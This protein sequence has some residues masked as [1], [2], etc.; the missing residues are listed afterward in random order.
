MTYFA[1]LKGINVTGNKTIKM[2]ELKA[3]FESLG[4][5]NIRTYI[6][7]GNVVFESPAKAEAVKKKIEKGISD[8]FGFSVAVIIRTIEEMNKIIKDYPFSKI[9]GHEECKISVGFLDALPSKAA[10]K[11]LEAF[12]T[13]N[14]KI[15][16]TGSTLYHLYRGNF[17]DSLVFKKNLPEKI[18]KVT[19]T[20]RNWNTTNKIQKI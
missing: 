13:D 15:K 18:L 3:M 9:K 1:L 20:I 7:S 16:V 19:C 4:F 14:E 5:K 2:A 10:V 8:K 12:N 6:Q 11:E 17:S